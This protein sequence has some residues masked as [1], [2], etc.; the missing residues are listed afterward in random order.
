MDTMKFTATLLTPGLK[1]FRQRRNQL[2]QSNNDG[3]GH[4]SQFEQT[5]FE[6]AVRGRIVGEIQPREEGACDRYQTKN[7]IM[8]RKHLDD[9]RV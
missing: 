9:S 5:Q 4:K 2:Y 6:I 1:K 7:Q 3:A 8:N